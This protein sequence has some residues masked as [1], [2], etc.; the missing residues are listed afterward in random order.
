MYLHARSLEITLPG[1][2]RK[3]FKSPLPQVFSEFT[4]K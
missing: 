4:E 2:V 3:V 1:G